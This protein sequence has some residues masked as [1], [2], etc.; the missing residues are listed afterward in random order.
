[1]YMNLICF[2]FDDLILLRSVYMSQQHWIDV[3]C[4]LGTPFPVVPVPR[5]RM[6]FPGR[7]TRPRS[8][9]PASKVQSKHLS[10]QT[11]LKVCNM[12]ISSSRFIF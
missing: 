5:S 8:A 1:V 7:G 10:D 6:K 2:L 11:L 3:A 9:F 4:D 12:Q